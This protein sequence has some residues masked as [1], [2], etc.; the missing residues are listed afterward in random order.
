MRS[1][2]GV[3]SSCYL[4]AGSSVNNNIVHRAGPN[5]CL[6]FCNLRVLALSSN[7]LAELRHQ[8]GAFPLKSALSHAANTRVRRLGN[9][10]GASQPFLFPA[11]WLSAC[12][13]EETWRPERSQPRPRPHVIDW[14]CTAS[15]RTS[16]LVSRVDKRVPEPI[17][18][19]RPNNEGLLPARPLS[20]YDHQLL[21]HRI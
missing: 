15:K 13:H 19:A 14:P 18:A 11:R 10:E 17:P 2:F 4:F 1:R 16:W 21:P 8:K 9:R 12:L 20:R 7:A 5:F 6:M 3:R